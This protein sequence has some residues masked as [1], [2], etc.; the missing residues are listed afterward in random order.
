VLRRHRA[1]GRGRVDEIKAGKRSADDLANLTWAINS[2]AVHSPE[3]AEAVY[4]F[5]E[6]SVKNAPSDGIT[7]KQAAVKALGTIGDILSRGKAF[8]FNPVTKEPFGV[9][10]PPATL[11]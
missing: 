7:A 8:R 11:K 5:L 3:Y 10:I 2:P 4:R 6:Y 1:G 9:P